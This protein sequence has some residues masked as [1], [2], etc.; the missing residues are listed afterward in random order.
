M[1]T[2]P[3]PVFAPASPSIPIAC[4][5]RMSIASDRVWV[6]DITYLRVRGS[7]R[8]LAIVHGSIF[9]AC[10]RVDAGR[11]DETARETCQSAC[12][13]ACSGRRRSA[14]AVIFHSDRGSEYMGATFCAFMAQQRP[15]PKRER[16]R[17]RRRMPTPSRSFTRSRR[18]SLAASRSS[19]IARSMRPS[20][21]YMR[22]YNARRLH[23][24]SG[25]SIAHCLRAPN[26][27]EL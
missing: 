9:A 25:V 19:P 6:G 14:G 1:A 7:W 12:A 16:P 27:I 4:G 10:A 5:R 20:R 8:Y 21:E 22:Y 15:A 11:A 18:S 13:R 3:R 24:A 23:S 26:R 17:T 2:A